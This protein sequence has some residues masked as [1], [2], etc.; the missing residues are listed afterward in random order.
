MVATLCCVFTQTLPEISN[1]VEEQHHANDFSPN[2]GFEEEQFHS[3]NSQEDDVTEAL[4]A[5]VQPDSFKFK[6]AEALSLSLDKS[7]QQY[8]RIRSNSES[9]PAAAD[10]FV[11]R[12]S[13][14]WFTRCP[15]E[16]EKR[17]TAAIKMKD[18]Q[19]HTIYQ[20]PPIKTPSVE[21]IYESFQLQLSISSS[22]RST[23][24]ST[25]IGIDPIKEMQKINPVLYL[26]PKDRHIL[27]EYKILYMDM[28]ARWKLFVSS[29]KIESLIADPSMINLPKC[30]DVFPYV[31]NC[32]TCNICNIC[33]LK[34][35]GSASYCLLC[36]HGGH[37][38]HMQQWFKKNDRCPAGCGCL[39]VK[40][41]SEYNGYLCQEDQ[42]V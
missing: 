19:Q 29:K 34:V 42:R 40:E 39:C 21:Q 27:D 35:Y 28:L 23:T 38:K 8:K 20:Q 30:A 22:K 2:V 33:Q 4:S 36:F 10:E 26:D 3:G 14:R 13:N 11:S 37:M 32:Q 1:I 12:I 5:S 17:N 7:K 41:M 18:H 16:S 15:S 24:C 31:R 6:T 25:T 9:V